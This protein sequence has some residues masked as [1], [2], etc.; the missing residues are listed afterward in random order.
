MVNGDMLWN[1]QGDR[2]TGD[3]LLTASEAKQMWLEREVQSLKTALNRVSVPTDC[4]STIWIL[5]TVVLKGNL[6]SCFGSVTCSCC[7]SSDL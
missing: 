2:K 6:V 7:Q 4:V 5:R 1:P 3:E